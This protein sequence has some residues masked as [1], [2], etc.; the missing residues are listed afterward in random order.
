MKKWPVILDER[1]TDT[2]ALEEWRVEVGKW[3]VD[4]GALSCSG[5]GQIFMLLPVHTFYDSMEI[6][7]EV[8]CS[9]PEGIDLSMGTYM[10]SFG[11]GGN[12]YTRISRGQEDIARTFDCTIQ[13]RKTHHIVARMAGGKASLEIDGNGV[14]E[15][16]DK[17]APLLDEASLIVCG[18]GSFRNVKVRGVA[19]SPGTPARRVAGKKPHYQFHVAVDFE[20]DVQ[21]TPFTLKMFD[22]MVDRCVELGLSR[23]Y[24]MYPGGKEGGLLDGGVDEKDT[25]FWRRRTGNAR[26]SLENIGD[27]LP[28][29]VKAA[30]AR[31][32]EVYSLI[33]P[34]ELAYAGT[35]RDGSE[36]AER[37]G[38][39]DCIGGRIFNSTHFLAGNPSLRIERNMAGIDEDTA[40]RIVRTIC[41]VKHDD[42]ESGIRPDLLEVWVSDDNATYRKYDKPFKAGETVE[43][44]PVPVYGTQGNGVGRE[45][46]PVRVIRLDGLE[47]AE[48][49]FAV[50]TP[51]PAGNGTFKNWIYALT[52]IISDEGTHIPFTYGLHVSGDGWSRGEGFRRAGFEFDFD[53]AGAAFSVGAAISFLRSAMFLD[54]KQGVIGFARGKNRYLPGAPCGAYRE[55]KDFWLS[56]V[57]QAIDAGADGVDFRVRN[58]NMT[59]E[60]EAYGFNPPIVEEYKQRYGVDIRTQDFDR[61]KWRR[62]RGEHYTSFLR[63]ARDLLHAAGKKIQLHVSSSMQVDPSHHTAMEIHWDWRRWIEEGLADALTLEAVNPNTMLYDEIKSMTEERNI[64]TYFC[65]FFWSALQYDNW[66]HSPQKLFRLSSDAGDD[67]FIL[68]ECAALMEG[69]TDGT[70]ELKH[71][72]LKETI[73][74]FRR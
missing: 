53:T 50:T 6:E 23:I 34:F 57:K 73:R 36:E 69:R 48:K 14:L 26:K 38:K 32:L 17:R 71:P 21:S 39:L 24:W 44:R 9:D 67:G 51:V 16:S 20:D 33:K 35:Y 1:F 49:Y 65:P 72:E 15:A 42:K 2:K 8:C 18:E 55:V 37:F 41:F 28:A 46:R 70:V 45:K 43:E 25:G 4:A 64:R 31:G 54:N 12:L 19:A 74:K 47:I 56:W 7:C 40:A 11:T 29:M 61:E 27:F 60:W 30:H 10:F 13:P 58:H 52:E 59:F 66:K 22:K 62:L 5:Y 63:E 68:Y 3:I